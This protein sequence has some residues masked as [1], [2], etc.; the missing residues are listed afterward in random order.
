MVAPIS[1]SAA[2]LV[3]CLH[4]GDF[5]G[6]GAI[7]SRLGAFCCSG[8]EAVFAILQRTGLDDF[9]AGD[10]A[11]GI[12]QKHAA[13][14]DPLRFA[15]LDDPAVA[16]RFISYHDGRIAHAAFSI[17][18]IHCASCVW[19][20]E[21]LW[22]FDAGVSRSEVDLFRRT[23]RVEYRPNDTS[24]RRVAEQLAV[25]GYEP[26][27][28]PEDRVSET[29]PS[30]RR[31]HLQ[32]GV[33]GF[34]AG[35]IMLF[36]IPRYANGAPLDSGFQHMFDALNVTLAVPVLL[37]SASDY[38]RSAWQALRTR[39]MALDVP[40]ALGL[41][42]LFLRSIV[43]IATGRSEGFL[44]S[45]A[46]LVLFLLLGRL[47][48]QKV[49]DRI[50]F[51]RTFRSFLPLSVRVERENGI[52]IVPLE[53][54]RTGDCIQ[55]RPHEVVP[56]DARVLDEE[57]TIDYAFITGEQAPVAVRYGDVVR[58][59]GRVA[60]AALRVSV[61][62]DVSHGHLASL[63]NNPVFAKAK[64]RWLT[65]VGSRFGG[66]FTWGAIGL[67]GAGAFAWWPD[68]PASATVATAVLIIAC[69]CALTLSAPITLGTAMGL[70]G[71]RGF[72]LKHP[73][74]A[75]DLS[76]VQVIAF[77]K[78][79]TLT[80]GVE[81]VVV[82]ARDMSR[83]AWALIRALARQ[84]VHPVSRAI[85][86]SALGDALDDA[87]LPVTA[88]VDVP[89]EGLSGTVDGIAVAIG[90]ARFV[91]VP[92]GPRATHAAAR[93]HVAAG[94]EQG[95][96][97]LSAEARPGAEA[98]ARALA[99]THE[100]CLLSGDDD[101]ERNRWAH[102][103][104]TRMRFRQ[105]PQ[106][107]LSFVADARR[108]GRYVLM[109]GD[110][111]NDAGALAAADVGLAVSDE[112]ACVVPACDAVIAGTR[113]ADLPA[114]L[115]YAARARSVVFVCFVVSI[116]YNAVGLTLALSGALTPLASAI[117]MPVSSLTIVGFSTGAMRWSARRML[118]S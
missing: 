46:G 45:F 87:P 92:E 6:A 25:L 83:R 41:A 9:Y 59:G 103:F 50:G 52:A 8:C 82:D 20:L 67:A 100:V 89:G 21:Q 61:L 49:F 31:L 7:P 90:T 30:R 27:V 53:H 60:G 44:D 97:R 42:I 29:P 10:D 35:N 116:A 39:T 4:C 63:W 104:G 95:W 57:G 72:Y 102:V 73:S 118:P 54:L 36:S 110:G 32:M 18:A 51:D 91:G 111:L 66:W 15:A 109:I 74:V 1:S 81:H 64:S 58:A 98:A 24:L 34:A 108:R 76:R 14:L 23:L 13:R 113:L 101:S 68:A 79:G 96:V 94:G 19:V 84:S 38:F 28:S 70:L 88:V 48:Q 65:E 75:F 43:D 106:D 69:P 11:P 37:F 3:P 62:R 2:A 78:T 77:D 86:A 105:T 47:F 114:F 33:A 22:R 17:P 71:S 93:T 55:V 56:A 12:S 16:D 99:L 115:R 26:T 112:T 80:G 40:V 117:L 107:K 5:C 85:A